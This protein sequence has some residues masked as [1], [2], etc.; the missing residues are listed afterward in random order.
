VRLLQRTTRRL[1][2]TAAGETYL[3]RVRSILSDLEAAEEAAHSHAREMSGSVRV[4]SLPA[5]RPRSWHR[6]SRRSAGNIPR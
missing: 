6:P 1:A 5:C 2:L 3:D 4:L